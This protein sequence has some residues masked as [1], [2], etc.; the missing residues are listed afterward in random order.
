MFD[1]DYF[2]DIFYSKDGGCNWL[3]KKCWFIGKVGQYEQCV[4]LVCMGCGWQ[5]MFKIIVLLLC[6]CDFFGGVLIVELM[7]D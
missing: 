5:W 1:I 7:D 2:V 3:N 4:K 6:K